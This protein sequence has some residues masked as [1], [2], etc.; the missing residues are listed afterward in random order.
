MGRMRWDREA[1]RWAYNNDDIA[2]RLMF[3][4]KYLYFVFIHEDIISRWRGD[5][6]YDRKYVMLRDDRA[7][8][9]SLC[10]HCEGLIFSLV[11]AMPYIRELKLSLDW[12]HG[13][14]HH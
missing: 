13:R 11:H 10:T 9:V 4:E 7:I 14:K 8:S 1:M 5:H 2:S 6:W 12:K 3:S